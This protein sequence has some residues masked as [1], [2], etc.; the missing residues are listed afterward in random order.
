ML[1]LGADGRCKARLGEDLL[2]M[3]TW[4]ASVQCGCSADWHS[5]CSVDRN[6]FEYSLVHTSADGSGTGGGGCGC[7]VGGA[8]AGPT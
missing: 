7:G 1:M 4:Q 8:G 6:V 5:P 2:H 3:S